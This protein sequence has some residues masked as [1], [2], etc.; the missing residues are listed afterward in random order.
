MSRPQ[1][2]ATSILL[3]LIALAFGLFLLVSLDR[4]SIEGTIANSR[5]IEAQFIAASAFVERFHAANH[6]LPSQE[7]FNAW[8]SPD[9]DVQ[10]GNPLM[11]W[12]GPFDAETEA[13]GGKAPS[14]GYVIAY[15]RGEWM[16]KHFSWTQRSTLQFD[17]NDYYFFN[18]Q[19]AQVLLATG[20]VLFFAAGSIWCWPRK[21]GAA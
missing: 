4:S 7:E 11:L 6:R 2:K 16:E 20:I 10:R 18:S 15:W 14:G 21:R 1:S 13:Q 8:I 17:P 3:A 5:R 9:K 12:G 19:M